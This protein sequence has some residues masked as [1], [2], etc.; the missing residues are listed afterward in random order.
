MKRTFFGALLGLALLALAAV[1]AGAEELTVSSILAARNAGAPNDGLIAMVNSPNNTVVMTAED[2]I[3]LRNAGV[4]ESVISAIWAHIPAPPPAPVPLQPNDARLV[5][6]VRLIQ[7]GLSESIIAEKVRQSGQAYNLSVNDLL[8]LKQNGAKES[9][10]AALMA[11]DIGTAAT[12][13]VAP[14]ELVFDDLVMLRTGFWKKDRTGRL[15][16]RGDTLGWEDSHD[17]GENVTFQITGLEKVWFTC[18]ARTPENFCYQIN[19]QIVKGDRYRFR[20]SHREL[21]SN[22]A[23]TKVM[24]ALRTYFPRIVFAAP[25]D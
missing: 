16:M 13:A 23:V 8:Y 25:E 3:T 17:P 14:A 1:S 18:E 19:F 20:D 12:P 4:S 10:I 5:D 9:T 6:L 7:S 22:A 11:T 24:Q 15:V 2:L 21:G